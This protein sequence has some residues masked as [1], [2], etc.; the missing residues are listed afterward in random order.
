MRV[1]AFLLV[2]SASA[3]MAQTLRIEP[4]PKALADAFRRNLANSR[5]A[6]R[7]VVITPQ[8][9]FEFDVPESRCSVRLLEAPVRRGESRLPV[10]KPA[11]TEKMPLAVLPVP[12]CTM[13]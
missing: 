12:P 10:I 6:E 7:I 11:P 3:C 2:C 5:G 9:V 8:D 4:V 1:V 13:R